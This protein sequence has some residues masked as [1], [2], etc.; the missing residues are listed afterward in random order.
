VGYWNI[1]TF[2][3]SSIS[4]QLNPTYTKQINI[5]SFRRSQN[6]KIDEREA[7]TCATSVVLHQIPTKLLKQSM[8]LKSQKSADYISKKHY[9]A[10]T[11]IRPATWSKSRWPLEVIRLPLSMEHNHIKV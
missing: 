2:W 3:Y 8:Y 4:E 7:T 11:V 9:G 1:L 10:A 6:K 5:R